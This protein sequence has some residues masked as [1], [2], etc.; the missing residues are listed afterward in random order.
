[1][2]RENPQTG[3]IR[4]LQLRMIGTA[5]VAQ[6][7]CPIELW[8]TIM[9]AATT[10]L[11]LPY[12]KSLAPRMMHRMFSATRNAFACTSISLLAY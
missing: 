8:K 2:S 4:V 5:L 12:A 10:R 9:R 6:M 1:M 11:L 7:M 3:D